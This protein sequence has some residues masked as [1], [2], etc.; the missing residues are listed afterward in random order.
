MLGLRIGLDIEVL[1]RKGE[2]EG[3]RETELG[4]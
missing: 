2:R 1:S 3:Y 4:R